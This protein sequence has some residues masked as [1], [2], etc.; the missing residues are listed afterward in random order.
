MINTGVPVPI[1][2]QRYALAPVAIPC[3]HVH[4]QQECGGGFGTSTDLRSHARPPCAYSLPS[5]RPVT[6]TKTAALS[7]PQAGINVVVFEVTL[8]FSW[9]GVAVGRLI[10]SPPLRSVGRI[11]TRRG[12]VDPPS[13]ITV[14]ELIKTP[15]TSSTSPIPR[16]QP[17]SLPGDKLFSVVVSAPNT[18]VLTSGAGLRLGSPHPT[19]MRSDVDIHIISDPS[20]FKRGCRSQQQ[21]IFI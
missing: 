8:P 11:G 6:I 5:P 12:A 21:T 9:E 7:A 10:F 16:P 20:A 15:K 2:D 18:F 17:I 4:A 14:P 3:A 19:C 13:R 1:S